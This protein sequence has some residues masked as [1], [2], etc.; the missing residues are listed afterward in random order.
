M[1]LVRP[2]VRIIDLSP[3]FNSLL[4][5]SYRQVWFIV[6]FVTITQTVTHVGGRGVEFDVALEDSN[7]FCNLLFSE[8]LVADI[9][10]RTLGRANLITVAGGELAI[11]RFDSLQPPYCRAIRIQRCWPIGKNC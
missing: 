9:I 3:D 2:E 1:F 5:I 10:H 6:R 7:G 8:Q 4:S 11:V